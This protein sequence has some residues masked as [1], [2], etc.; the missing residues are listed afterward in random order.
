[1]GFQIVNTG[2][3]AQRQWVPVQTSGGAVTLYENQLVQMGTDGVTALGA[4]SG[5]WNATNK[6]TYPAYGIPYGIVIGTS[7]RYELY[8]STYNTQKITSMITSNVNFN[9][10]MREVGPYG[11]DQQAYVY[12]ERIFP[13]TVLRG[14]VYFSTL[15]TAPTVSTVLT[16]ATGGATGVGFTTAASIGFTG[17]ASQT[18]LCFRSG[19]NLGLYRIGSDTST[20][21][22]TVPSP[23]PYAIAIGDTLVAANLRFAGTA[24]VQFDSLSLGVLADAAATSDYFGIEVSRLDLS[25]A[26]KEY[27]DFRFMNIMFDPLGT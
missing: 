22:K 9:V 3:P 5:V 15:G 24:R 23:F 25:T 19:A 21:V 17:V 13:W 26:G 14:P 16:L 7:R 2:E 11:I 4:A 12:V 20:T 27:V 18:T 10:E 8:D 1:M 6:T